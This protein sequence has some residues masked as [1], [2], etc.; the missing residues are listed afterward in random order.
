M[1]ELR[2][3]FSLAAYSLNSYAI[4][5][6]LAATLVLIFGIFL[7]YLDQ[8]AS[9]NRSL[10]YFC[11]SSAL[12]LYSCV[13]ILN[14]K[15]DSAAAFWAHG[16]YA[17]FVIVPAAVFH[18]SSNLINRYE[19][20]KN[21]VRL[22]YATAVV[23]L[24][25]CRSPYF[26]VDMKKDSF[27]FYPTAG[28]GQPVM[29]IFFGVCLLASLANLIH[30]H[31]TAPD[32]EEK[33]RIQL[34]IFS[35]FVLGTA[36]VDILAGYD[37]Y[38]YPSG[39]ISFLGFMIGITCFKMMFYHDKVER[40]AQELEAEVERKTQ[41]L[42]KVLNDLRA[43][44]F[45]LLETGKKSALASL[46]AGILHQI[47]QPITAIHGFARF[48]KKEMKETETFYK[49]ICHIEEQSVYI[50]RMLE[51]LMNLVRHR[52]IVKEVVDINV[53]VKRAMN[54][55]TDELR[56]R[57]VNWDL[58]LAENLPAVYADSVHLQQIF[59]NLVINS[60]QAMENLPRGIPKTMR[61]VSAPDNSQREIV[62]TF[63]DSAPSLSEED[64]KILQ[65]TYFSTRSKASV[66]GLA[67]CQDLMAE[68]G[69]RIELEDNPGEGTTFLLKFPV[70]DAV[71]MTAVPV[72]K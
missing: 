1:V 72:R 52:E 19:A 11:F 36:V 61:I 53:V 50:K 10:L 41:E 27:S 31:Y 55:L 39:F 29:L 47:S 35:F 4:A 17:G 68:H 38:L 25:F 54:L 40:H 26:F 48:V 8:K 28:L 34:F 22:M 71:Q 30:C 42:S 33:R 7:N 20:Q 60:L 12:W 6:F 18:L 9:F 44:Q 45:K 15:A 46:S 56:I 66:I 32:R 51:D 69:G 13:L 16:L 49:P 43:M 59:M 37:L 67:L 65:E 62:I 3:I 5:P 70:A 63:R 2:Q 64:K 23:L 57:R 21:I 14:A 58:K 24:P